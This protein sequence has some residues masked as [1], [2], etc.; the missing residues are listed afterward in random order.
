MD[1][2]VRGILEECRSSGVQEKEFQEFREFKEFNETAIP[3][4]IR[5]CFAADIHQ[6]LPRFAL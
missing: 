2:R 1:M 6:R 3:V 4:R 5:R